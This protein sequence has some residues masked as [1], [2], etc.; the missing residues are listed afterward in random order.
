VKSI[1]ILTIAATLFFL[2]FNGIGH[3][4]S[5]LPYTDTVNLIKTLLS[6]ISSD[7]RQESYG[8]IRFDECILDYNVSGYY[9]IGTPYD[10]S[11]RHIDFSSLNYQ[12]SK[13]GADSSHFV[14]LIFN[15]PFNYKSTSKDMTASTAVIDAASYQQAQTLFKAF[16]HLGELCGAGKSPL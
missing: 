16:L 1:N 11:F 3:C 2:S 6:G 10:I 5:G 14:I 13:T 12:K 4:D 9:P 7:V 8:Y 15:K